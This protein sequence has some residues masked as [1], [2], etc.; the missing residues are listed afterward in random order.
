[1]HDWISP[2]TV[3][4]L[5]WDKWTTGVWVSRNL[6]APQSNHL[7]WCAEKVQFQ[8]HITLAQG[9][10]GAVI[11]MY[12]QNSHSPNYELRR[13]TSN[14]TENSPLII[15]PLL[16]P[17]SNTKDCG[18]STHFNFPSSP[19][20]P[21][22]DFRQ[23][24]TRCSTQGGSFRCSPSPALLSQY[25]ECG[26][27]MPIAACLL[28]VRGILQRLLNHQHLLWLVVTNLGLMW[29]W[30]WYIDW[31]LLKSHLSIEVCWLRCMWDVILVTGGLLAH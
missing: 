3:S 16:N 25:V 30:T 10:R 26:L 9:L 15:V 19:Q 20:R 13:I 17:D 24:S 21:D 11:A 1:M 4:W 23:V 8:S 2:C 22:Q 29:F 18:V 5:S 31:P 14:N 6:S 27:M 28:V 12:G 7:Q